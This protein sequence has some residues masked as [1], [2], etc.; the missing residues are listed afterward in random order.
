[1]YDVSNVRK[2]TENEGNGTLVWQGIMFVCRQKSAETYL[3]LV[4]MATDPH[5][6]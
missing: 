1:M 2:I 5:R 3:V 4:P 6:L